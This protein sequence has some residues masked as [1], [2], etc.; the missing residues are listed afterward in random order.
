MQGY[1]VISFGDLDSSVGNTHESIHGAHEH[2]LLSHPFKDFLF[3]LAHHDINL[4]SSALFEI[5]L[6]SFTIKVRNLKTQLF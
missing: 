5:H 4:T 1:S 6:H 3:D 2:N